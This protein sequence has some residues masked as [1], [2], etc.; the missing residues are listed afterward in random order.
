[1]T[2]DKIQE[3]LEKEIKEREEKYRGILIIMGLCLCG[4][5]VGMLFACLVKADTSQD[6]LQLVV[7][8]AQGNAER[9]TWSY[10]KQFMCASFVGQ[11]SIKLYDAHIKMNLK[12]G[13]WFQ[14]GDGTCSYYNYRHFRCKH[15]WLEAVLQNGTIIPIETTG[16]YII[17]MDEYRRDYR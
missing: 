16:G 14:N 1:M 7:K 9:H 6:Q 17:P 15:Y 2:T 3:E 8:L 11:L 10:D 13:K 12:S 4:F 5:L